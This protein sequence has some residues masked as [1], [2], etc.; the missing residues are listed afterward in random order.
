VRLPANYSVICTI[1]TDAVL[2]FA[3]GITPL[4]DITDTWLREYAKGAI[5]F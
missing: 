5:S 3:T 2:G 4:R 1:E